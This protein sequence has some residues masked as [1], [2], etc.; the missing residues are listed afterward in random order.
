MKETGKWLFRRGKTF[1]PRSYE[2][3]LR[4]KN[5]QPQGHLLL[6]KNE[7]HRTLNKTTQRSITSTCHLIVGHNRRLKNLYMILE[8]AERGNLFY[9]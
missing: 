2:Q 3:I 7:T 5:N 8:Y 9:Y 1:Y 4:N 6:T